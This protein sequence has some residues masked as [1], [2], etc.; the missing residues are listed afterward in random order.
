MSSLKALKLA[1]PNTELAN[2]RSKLPKAPSTEEDIHVYGYGQFQ[3]MALLCS[4]VSFFMNVVHS[5][6][7]LVMSPTVAHWCKPPDEYAGLSVDEWKNTSIPK[8]VDGQFSSCTRY[9]PPMPT[10]ADNKSEVSCD[11][12]DYDSEVG[13]TIV[14][15]FSLVCDRKWLLRAL[16]FVYSLGGSV[17]LP[18]MGSA[19]DKSWRRA[20]LG[21]T[22]FGLVLSSVVTSL[23]KTLVEFA[24]LQLLTSTS[25]TTFQA[26]STVLLAEVTLKDHRMLFCMLNICVPLVLGTV[27]L[28]L[29]GTTSMHWS[30]MQ[31]VV[32]SPTLLLL[33]TYHLTDECPRWLITS[34]KFKEAERVIFWAARKNG[35][36]DL[37]KYKSFGGGAFPFYIMIGI[38]NMFTQTVSYFVLS[39][40]GRRKPMSAYFLGLSVLMTSLVALVAL[41]M[42]L[43]FAKVAVLTAFLVEVSFAT[44]FVFTVELYPT[45]VRSAVMCGAFLFGRLGGISASL[46]SA[47]RLLDPPMDRL[48]PKL[49]NAVVLF[50]LGLLV[51]SLPETLAI[52]ATDK[53]QEAALEDKW[54]LDSPLKRKKKSRQVPRKCIARKLER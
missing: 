2:I 3:R 50:T 15:D 30:A 54:S 13:A 34:W 42:E 43:A 23:V 20:A 21:L 18:I 19:A 8:D 22:L 49:V 1:N 11:C 32:L 40:Y 48:I 36:P 4:I 52:S 38:A 51:L 5:Q 46:F 31:L 26:I 41:G 10:P 28:G 7:L 37:D 25:I 12:W 24:V 47:L 53:G 16:R 33:L 35:I 6:T 29:I 44:M 39:G 14:R 9:E 27:V 45:A 17:R